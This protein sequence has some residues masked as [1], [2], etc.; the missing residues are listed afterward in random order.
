MLDGLVRQ[1]PGV[2]LKGEKIC[3]NGRFVESQLLNEKDFFKGNNGVLLNNLPNYMVN[4][5]T[6][7]EKLGDDSEF[8]GYEV[9]NDI[10]YVM[11]VKLKKQYS[12]G[13][14]GNVELGGGTDEKYLA[15]LFVMR[16]TNHSRL[17]VYFN[18][19]NMNDDGKP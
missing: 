8:L 16:F 1:L 10:R 14:S 17:A 7:Y 5:V 4:K 19:N 6:V 9:A 15:R 11:D 12:V 2:E 3:V 13:F 18:A